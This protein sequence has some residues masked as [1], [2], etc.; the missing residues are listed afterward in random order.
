MT[1]VCVV[2]CLYCDGRAILPRQS[3]LGKFQGLP[4]PTTASWPAMFLCRKCERTY[5]GLAGTIRPSDEQLPGPMSGH[6]PALWQIEFECERE[7]CGEPHVLYS[8]WLEGDTAGRVEAL[9][10]SASSQVPCRD[11]HSVQIASTKEPEM[12]PY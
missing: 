6:V 3:R 8:R 9:A 12:W 2:P 4:N 11:G 5:L 7:N 1:L 10:V